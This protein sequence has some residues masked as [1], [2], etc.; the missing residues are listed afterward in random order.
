MP[1]PKR[2]KTAHNESNN[3]GSNTHAWADLTAQLQEALPKANQLA[4]TDGQLK[5]FTT[6]NA[7]KEKTTFG[8]KAAG[9][10]NTITATVSNGKCEIGTGK[11]SDCAFVLSALPEQWQEFF[12][13]TPV[14]P[15]QS[16]WGMCTTTGARKYR[17]T[18]FKA[19][20]A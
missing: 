4:Q 19:C 16:Y 7:V 15:Y 8:V 18:S 5:A 6:T 17:L 12:K 9:S 14:A 2:Q 20:S 11:T 10:D 3:M 1:R 13:Q